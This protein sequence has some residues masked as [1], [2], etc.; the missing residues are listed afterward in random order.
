MKP[1]TIIQ[2]TAAGL[3][4]ALFAASAFAGRGHSAGGGKGGGNG[5]GGGSGFDTPEQVHLA[6]AF[7]DSASDGVESDG[8]TYFDGDLN[9]AGE[10]P[11]LDAHIDISAGGNYGNLYLRTTNTVDRSLGLD[12]SDCV[13]DCGNQPFTEEWFHSAALKV[14]ATESLSGGL[15]AMSD[16]QV[17]TAPMQITYSFSANEAPGFVHFQPGI[18]GKSPCK[19]SNGSAEVSITRI[20]DTNWAVSGDAACVVAPDGSAG[21]VVVMPFEFSVI[22][23]QPC[24]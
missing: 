23:D 17:V 20:D 9:I 8:G 19:G 6:I 18:K 10:D 13:A 2:S 21:G 16:G 14:A 7:R 5:G 3:C 24:F 11:D 12:I 1:S 4:I 22:G 15:C